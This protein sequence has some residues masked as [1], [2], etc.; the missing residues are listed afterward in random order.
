MEVHTQLDKV[1]N[2]EIKIMKQLPAHPN[3]IRMNEIIDSDFEDKLLIV[4]EWC[5]RR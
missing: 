1:Y 2:T 4:M 5:E 3:I